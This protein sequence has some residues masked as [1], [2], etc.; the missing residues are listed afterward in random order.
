MASSG[1]AQ[2]QPRWRQSWDT[3]V[4]GMARAVFYANVLGC[5]MPLMLLFRTSHARCALGFYSCIMMPV[6]VYTHLC[7]LPNASALMWHVLVAI[8]ITL[9]LVAVGGV[10]MTAVR[11]PGPV[12]VFACAVFIMACFHSLVVPTIHSTNFGNL[13]LQALW[14]FF[15][16]LTTCAW[17]W[18]FYHVVVLQM[19]MKKHKSLTINPIKSQKNEDDRVLVIGNAPS[20]VTG[21]ALGG[22]ID[23]FDH[24]V[25]FNEYAVDKP[26]Y[27]GSKVTHHFC[28]GRN[29]PKNVFV[30]G[31]LPL[32]NASLTHSA[33]LFMPHL[34]EARKFRDNLMKED[35]N[36]WVVDEP[37]VMKLCRKLRLNF[38]QVP[39]SGM[40]A[41]DSFLSDY[42]EIT[43]HGFNFFQGKKIHYFKESPTQL[44]TSWLERFC[45]HNPLKEKKWVMGLEKEGRVSFLANK[46][47]V[48]T[49][50]ALAPSDNKTV[51]E[52][53]KKLV[54]EDADRLEQRA[55]AR[56]RRPG[57]F[58][59]FL[60]D[61]F[62]SQFSL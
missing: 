7:L 5:K 8:W 16:D 34:E 24:V 60:E 55:Q 57:F 49:G 3:F 53:E 27:T 21:I 2:S 6:C 39:T 25:R 41:I 48:A 54:E 51:E 19:H 44:I 18:C 12:S 28:N 22:E 11:R 9:P 33:Y 32:F 31:C 17:I 1:V 37:R 13:L 52:K 62:P 30:K 38:W 58:A 20:V 4:V 46:F 59:T 14:F 26:D 42:D 23:G 45:T 29:M 56:R 10:I 47:Q 35:V 50:G 15:E 61:G 43:L 36:A 40:V